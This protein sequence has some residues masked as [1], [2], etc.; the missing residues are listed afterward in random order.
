MRTYGLQD[1]KSRYS[2]TNFGNGILEF[3]FAM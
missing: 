1:L 2:V 3:E